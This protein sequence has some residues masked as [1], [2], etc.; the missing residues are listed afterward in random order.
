MNM[1]YIERIKASVVYLKDGSNYKIARGKKDYIVNQYT[2]F[3]I[4]NDGRN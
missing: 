3:V 1:A 4:K 2:A